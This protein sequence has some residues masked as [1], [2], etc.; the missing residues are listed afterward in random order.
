MLAKKLESLL[1]HVPPVERFAKRVY[2]QRR[3]RT[4]CS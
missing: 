2:L 1:K 4:D 3:F